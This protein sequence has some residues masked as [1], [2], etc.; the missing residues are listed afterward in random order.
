MCN[1]SAKCL[2]QSLSFTTLDVAITVYCNLPFCHSAILPFG[3]FVFQ[4][5]NKA[6]SERNISEFSKN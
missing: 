3:I 4:T 6:S 2:T 5:G 1:V